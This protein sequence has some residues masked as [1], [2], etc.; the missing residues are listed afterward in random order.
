MGGNPEDGEDKH[1][2]VWS[3]LFVGVSV[4]SSDVRI[5][6]IIPTEVMKLVRGLESVFQGRGEST[7]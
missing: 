6:F 7:R 5:S 4:D 1:G 3:L 2:I